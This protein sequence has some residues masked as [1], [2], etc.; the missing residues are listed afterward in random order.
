MTI[1]TDLFIFAK[2]AS[3]VC[4]M[5]FSIARIWM[6]LEIGTLVVGWLARNTCNT[7][8]SQLFFA[9]GVLSPALKNFDK[10]FVLILP[11]SI[12]D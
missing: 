9:T 10:I 12:H 2:G 8:T 1:T 4:V 7:K 5:A 3:L 11:N 6:P